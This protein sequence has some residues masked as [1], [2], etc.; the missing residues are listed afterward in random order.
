MTQKT[1]PVCPFAGI[2]AVPKVNETLEGPETTLDY[3]NVTCYPTCPLARILN[4]EDDAEGVEWEC[5]VKTIGNVTGYL[6]HFIQLAEEVLA[7][8][9]ER[10]NLIP[11]DFFEKDDED[12]ED[13]G[14]D[15]EEP[16]PEPTPPAPKEEKPEEPKPEPEP[17]PEPPKKKRGRPK[18]QKVEA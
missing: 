7:Q 2:F 17:A 11:D 4:D 14:G 13:E 18:K 16:A 1:S 8:W 15:E 10:E 12:D 5:S 9:A 6:V 3:V